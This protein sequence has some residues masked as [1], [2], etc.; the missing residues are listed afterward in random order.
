MA[1][2]KALKFGNWLNDPN[3]L[4]QLIIAAHGDDKRGAGAGSGPGQGGDS[5][6][7]TGSGT[8]A[9]DG[10]GSF[11]GGGHAGPVAETVIVEYMPRQHRASHAAAGNS[12]IYPHNGAVRLR[13]E[14]ECADRLVEGDDQWARIIG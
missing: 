4:L 8:G 10:T 13:C 9:G 2:N 1:E 14:R 12:G 6:G 3:K 7:G 5:S 11:P